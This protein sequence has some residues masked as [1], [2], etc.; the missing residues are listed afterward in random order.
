MDLYF[1][2]APPFENCTSIERKIVTKYDKP[3]QALDVHYERNGLCLDT[4]VEMEHVTSIGYGGLGLSGNPVEARVA[5]ARE[6]FRS[7][8]PLRPPASFFD[9]TPFI[10]Y[11]GKDTTA[12]KIGF[13]SVYYGVEALI[14]PF[15]TLLGDNFALAFAGSILEEGGRTRFP[16]GG[17]LRWT[18]FGS[19]HATESQEFIPNS[20]KFGFPGE[21]ADTV[22]AG[23]TEVPSLGR[24]PDSTVFYMHEQTIT[25]SPFRAYLYAEGGTVLNSNFSGAG[26]N[27]SANPDDYSQYYL[28]IGGGVLLGKWLTASLGYRYMRLNLRT[29]CAFCPGDVFIQNTDQ[30]NSVL[31]KIGVN[32]G[33]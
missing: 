6:L 26:E 25:M 18:I 4:T 2:N 5:P 17:N 12:R 9:V 11:G 28:G 10:G 27:P 21:Q 33:Y 19:S 3:I 31:L 8:S 7:H 23:Y 22:P 13:A 16:L 15:G 29:P 20:C 30:S 32:I 1:D 14:A 24:A